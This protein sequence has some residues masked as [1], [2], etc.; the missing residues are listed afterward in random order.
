[1]ATP[2]LALARARASA[3]SRSITAPTAAPELQRTACSG[4][5]IAAAHST[6]VQTTLAAPLRREPE[7]EPQR[8]PEAEPQREAEPE[9]TVLAVPSPTKARVG[10]LQP[11]A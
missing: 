7:A 1:M 4:G 2:N 8:E 5:P 3:I 6:K 9:P 10:A 11:A